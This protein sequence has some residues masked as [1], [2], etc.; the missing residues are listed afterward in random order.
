MTEKEQNKIDE[1]I[2][3]FI[4]CGDFEKVKKVRE[5]VGINPQYN[6]REEINTIKR[7]YESVLEERQKFKSKSFFSSTSGWMVAYKREK[8]EYRTNEDFQLKVFHT[9]VEYSDA[10]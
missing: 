6:A 2:D 9:F 1:V 4:D 7:L 8:K 5:A 10:S 3:Y